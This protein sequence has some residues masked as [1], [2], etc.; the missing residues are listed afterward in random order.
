MKEPGKVSQLAV[1]VRVRHNAWP[2][3]AILL[4]VTVASLSVPPCAASDVGGGGNAV[5]F[6]RDGIGAAGRA[7]G[8]AWTALASGS[9][10]AFWNP[11]PAIQTPSVMVGGAY[12]ERSGGLFALNYLGAA[13]TAE[14]WG[15]SALTVQSEMYDVY[16]LAGG[17][18]WRSF[19]LG[20]GANAYVF[21][22]PDQ[23]GVGL[24]LAVGCRYG[25]QVERSELVVAL[26]SKDV[27]WTNIVW[28]ALDVEEIDFASWVTRAALAV[29]SPLGEGRLTVEADAELAFHRPPL[30][31]EVDY[32]DKAVEA[33]VCAGIEGSWRSL[34][35]RLGLQSLTLPLAEARVRATVGVGFTYSNLSIDLTLIPSALGFTYLGEF[36]V[37]F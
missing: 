5:Q 26:A 34:R 37:G 31:G 3:V 13:V 23:R 15:I 17:L 6:L 12:E 35:G 22:V 28:R 18:V 19:S 10:S 21:G 2:L 8:G 29:S 27:G 9:T 16:L 1:F 14:E 4:A 32:W 30:E 20:I 24:G 36:N 7:M 33:S 11:A 25:A